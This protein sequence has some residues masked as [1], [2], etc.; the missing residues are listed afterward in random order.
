MGL[1]SDGGIH[2]HINHLYAICDLAIENKLE[3]IFIHG[4]TDG[5]DTDPKSGL[6][7]ITSLIHPLSHCKLN[8]IKIINKLLFICKKC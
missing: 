1:L 6:G 2:S 4:F 5:R 3:N 8:R 7:F